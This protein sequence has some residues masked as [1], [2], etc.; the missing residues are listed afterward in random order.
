MLPQDDTGYL[1]AIAHL[2]GDYAVPKEKARMKIR[3]FSLL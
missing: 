3:A 1:E 2:T